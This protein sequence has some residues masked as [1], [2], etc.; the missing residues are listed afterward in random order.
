VDDICALGI[1]DRRERGWSGGARS[2]L[3][4]MVGVKVYNLHRGDARLR[5]PRSGNCLGEVP[6]SSPH[7]SHVVPITRALIY[8]PWLT[9]ATQLNGRSQYRTGS[10]NRAAANDGRPTCTELSPIV[11]VLKWEIKRLWSCSKIKCVEKGEREY[12]GRE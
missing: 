10:S 6:L 7:S 5:L 4:A 8:L 1:W 9:S 11:E 3:L 2:R 12:V